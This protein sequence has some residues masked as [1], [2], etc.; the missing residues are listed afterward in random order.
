MLLVNVAV[1]PPGAVFRTL[2]TNGLT[3]VVVVVGTSE[4]ETVNTVWISDV[5]DGVLGAP[6]G[7]TPFVDG[8]DAGPVPAELVAV[9][10][11]V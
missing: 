4:T 10:V 9:T 5:I 8:A 6:M 2:T 11:K 3:V 1:P 7:T